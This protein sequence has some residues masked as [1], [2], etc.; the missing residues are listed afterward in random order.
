MKTVVLVI[1]GLVLLFLVGFIGLAGYLKIQDEGIDLTSRETLNLTGSVVTCVDNTVTETTDCA[2]TGGGGSSIHDSITGYRI[3][4]Y[5]PI[6]WTAEV[7]F[8]LIN[9]LSSTVLTGLGNGSNG[10]F[11]VLSNSPDSSSYTNKIVIIQHDSSFSDA[12]NRFL[13]NNQN[14][15]IR[16]LT[17]GQ[18]ISFVYDG[19]ISRWRELNE[20][21]WTSQFDKVCERLISECGAFTTSGT[22]ASCQVILGNQTLGT[23]YS[24]WTTLECDTGSTAGGFAA[25]S[26]YSSQHLSS[27][28]HTTLISKLGVSVLS[29]ATNRYWL[30][31]GIN[32]VPAVAITRNGIYW[33]YYN[34]D[35]NNNWHVCME[36]TSNYLTAGQCLDSGIPVSVSYVWLG[37]YIPPAQLTS[38]DYATFF[39]SLDGLTW[40]VLHDHHANG[41]AA[42][43]TALYPTVSIRKIVGTTQRNLYIDNWEIKYITHGGG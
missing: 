10:R 27:T 15:G 7:S 38:N 21:N 40:T 30:S 11:I 36:D 6:L 12:P 41:P 19:S 14:R 16:F 8:V 28:T 9:P 32:E 17:V 31:M 43:T 35:F 37:V 24:I 22:G 4:N 33:Y 42:G 18:S 1:L 23:D 5:T 39:Y 29:D 13:L 3:D 26:N 34:V 20:D 25:L 2:F